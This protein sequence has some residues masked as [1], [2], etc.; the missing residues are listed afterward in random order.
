MNNKFTTVSL[1]LILSL[2]IMFLAANIVFATPTVTTDKDV[3]TP[4]ET[5]V[6]S[7]SGLPANTKLVVQINRPGGSDMYPVRSDSSGAFTLNYKLTPHRSEDSVYTVLVIEPKT[8]TVLAS[9]SFS[10]PP[11]IG[12]EKGVYRTDQGKWTTG[13]A[14]SAYLEGDWAFYT[15]AVTGVNTGNVPSFNVN[16]NF[17][18]SSS[19]AVFIDAFTNFRYCWDCPALPDGTSHPGTS[20]TT[21]KI[22]FPININ[23]EYSGG[24]CL[25]TNDVEPPAVEHCFRVTGGLMFPDTLMSSGSH[26]LRIFFEAHLA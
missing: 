4:G 1:T 9:T 20:T 10:D 19:N 17:Y 2:S 14:G 6:I 26:T 24:S 12:Y 18:Q 7:G 3:Y 8:G 23:K 21:W 11:G 22:W 25:A 13:N 5:V 16:F 15:Y